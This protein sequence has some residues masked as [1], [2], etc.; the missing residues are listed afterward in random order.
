MG[1]MNKPLAPIHAFR[2]GRHVSMA[3]LEVTITP[4]DLA[5]TA[6]AYNPSKHEA[7]IVVGHPRL[8]APAYGWVAGV[9]ADGADLYVTH[10]QVDAAFAEMV[11]AGRFKKRSASFYPPDH[12]SN[13]VPGVWYLKHVGFLG[14]QPPA[15]KG[16]RDCSFADD[17]DLVT[18]EFGE[19]DD[20]TNAGMWRRL[21]EWIIARF[22]LDEADKVI[23]GW[24]V[25]SLEQSAQEEIKN[26][27]ALPG[28]ADHKEVPMTETER[29]RL[30]EAEAKAA[31][32][33]AENA[34]LK[35]E[36][37]QFAEAQTRL[38]EIETA[39][40]NKEIGDFVD[41]LVKAGRVLPVDR[42]ALAAFMERGAGDFTIEFGEGDA[43]TSKPSVQWLR[44]FLARLPVQVD[45]A[46]R[47]APSDENG[48]AEFASPDNYTADPAALEL[49]RK[50]KAHQAANA[51]V[52]FEASVAA[53]S[54]K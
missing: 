50:A 4:A 27:P 34:R 45:F 10:K 14:A 3:G 12:P 43:K 51:G 31:K 23:P 22:G 44:E 33:E 32:L 8:D 46:E 37:T 48:T 15:V 18:V 24:D 28:F 16:L 42:V 38:R 52:T 17:S 9:S 49:Y 21:R 36:E 5:E 19:Y 54:K 6:K 29:K 39:A 26:D 53:V 40:K 30:E 25:S 7:P 41:A 2:A 1:D 11:N 13:P 47:S 20:M 35:S